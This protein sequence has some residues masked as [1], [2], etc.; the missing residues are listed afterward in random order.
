VRTANGSGFKKDSGLMEHGKECED[1]MKCA[2]PGPADR[3]EPW[4]RAVA[5]AVITGYSSGYAIGLLFERLIDFLRLLLRPLLSHSERQSFRQCPWHLNS[6]D[7]PPS[8][9]PQRGQIRLRIEEMSLA[10]SDACCT[11]IECITPPTEKDASP[12]EEQ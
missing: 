5:Q 10:V 11:V 4:V 2:R 9:P 1:E 7:A 6:L 3:A 8:G 12:F